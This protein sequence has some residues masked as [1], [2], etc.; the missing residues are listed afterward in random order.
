MEGRLYNNALQLNNVINFILN[1]N[2]NGAFF[3]L[4]AKLFQSN[5]IEFMKTFFIK[6]TFNISVFDMP[7]ENAFI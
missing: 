6:L 5:T 7:L 4:L 1:V 3:L 2:K